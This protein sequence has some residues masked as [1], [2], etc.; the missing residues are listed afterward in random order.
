MKTQ[1]ELERKFIV[2]RVPKYMQ[3][4]YVDTVLITQNYIYVDLWAEIRIREEIILS[5][6][7]TRYYEVKKIGRGD[8]RQEIITEID[9]EVAEPFLVNSYYPISKQRDVYFYDGNFISVDFFENAGI[10]ELII[11]EVEFPTRGEMMNFTP[12]DWFIEEVTYNEEYKN[13]NIWQG[14]NKGVI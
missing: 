7:E 11:A 4:F 3:D 9:G 5:T 2:R 1:Q 13:K 12:Y 10:D 14:I 6:G 8:E